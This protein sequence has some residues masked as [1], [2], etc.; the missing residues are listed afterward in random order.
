MG[1]DEL[2]EKIGGLAEVCDEGTEVIVLGTV[3][4]VETYRKLMQEGVSDY[5]V[6]PFKPMQ[7]F[8]AIEAVTLDE[9]EAPRGRVIA[10]MGVRGGVG[11]STVAHNVAWSLAQLFDDDVIVLDL[12][13]AFGTLGLAF[14]AESEQGINDAL[15]APDRI[16]EVLLDRYLA[17]P[18]DHVALLTS[19]GSLDSDADIDVE[20]FDVL[21]DLVRQSAP[22]VVLDVPHG[23]LSWTQ[24][25]LMQADEIVI[26]AVLDLASL[27]DAKNVVSALGPKRVND[28]PIRVVINHAG[29]FRKT[30]LSVKDFESAVGGEPDLVVNHDPVLFGTA[31]NNGQMIGAMNP[32]HRV[33]E[34]FSGL[35]RVVSGTEPPK[36]E[37]KK[38]GL[39]GLI[40]K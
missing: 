39:L 27:R 29:A 13:L 9:T 36:K 7:M 37:K 8:E 17:R 12:D 2:V 31:S 24:H 14:N 25:V 21:L 32:R 20:S 19:P 1:G 4:D 5:L 35:A 40:K 33:V 28:P 15:A 18:E 26:T 16:D 22:F 30:E 10:F 3:N 38:S 23:W 11:S 34:A 6:P